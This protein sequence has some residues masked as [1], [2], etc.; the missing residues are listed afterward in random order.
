MLP[1]AMIDELCLHKIIYFSEFSLWCILIIDQ[2]VTFMNSD[3]FAA[4]FN[5]TPL[6]RNICKNLQKMASINQVKQPQFIV[7][8]KTTQLKFKCIE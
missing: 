1:A 2:G 8:D 5:G 4:A 6:A 7:T 3:I